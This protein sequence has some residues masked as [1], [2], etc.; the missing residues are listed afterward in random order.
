MTNIECCSIWHNHSLLRISK[1]V[2]IKLKTQFIAEFG[3]P[4]TNLFAKILIITQ[5]MHRSASNTPND[6]RIFE[7]K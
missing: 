2:I 1:L 3:A 7:K 5:L 6:V 4:I